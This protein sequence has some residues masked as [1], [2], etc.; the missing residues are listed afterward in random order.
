MRHA[1]RVGGGQT[2]AI[3]ALKALVEQ[4]IGVGAEVRVLAG[5]THPEPAI[6]KVNRTVRC[7]ERR[8]GVARRIHAHELSLDLDTVQIEISF[9]AKYVEHRRL[10]FP[11]HHGGQQSGPRLIEQGERVG[12]IGAGGTASRRRDVHRVECARYVDEGEIDRHHC[13]SQ[14]RQPF[15]GGAKAQTNRAHQHGCFGSGKAIL[16]PFASDGPAE[17][18]AKRIKRQHN[19]AGDGTTGAAVA[20]DTA[21][22]ASLRLRLRGTDDG[23]RGYNRGG[24]H[25]DPAA[26]HREVATGGWR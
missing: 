26:Y 14:Q 6:D 8:G 13:G 24:A 23:A 2:E 20:H 1:R 18:C 17:G 19:S 5:R 16:T 10:S 9:V 21:Q 3:P 15:R 22:F 12:A 11:R 4:H 7:V 25:E